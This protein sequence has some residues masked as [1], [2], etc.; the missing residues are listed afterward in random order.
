MI[1]N[2]LYLRDFGCYGE[3]SIDFTKHQVWLIKGK[4]RDRGG[5]S[6]GSGKSTIRD[7]ISWALWGV[8]RGL[9]KPGSDI[10]R[11]GKN[12]C[13]VYVEF[14]ANGKK[15][16]VLRSTGRSAILRFS[17]YQGQTVT[18]T[19]QEIIKFLGIDYDAFSKSACFEQGGSDAFS[20]LKPAEAKRYVINLL[21]LG[22]YSTLEQYCRRIYDQAQSQIQIY[23]RDVEMLSGKVED[24]KE[25][26]R[27][28]EVAQT[29]KARAEQNLSNASKAVETADSLLQDLQKKKSEEEKKFYALREELTA[30]VTQGRLQANRKVNFEALQGE[31]PTCVQEVPAQHKARISRTFDKTLN[32]LREKA[33]KIKAEVEAQESK[34]NSINIEEARRRVNTCRS[35]EQACQTELRNA[36]SALKEV[37]VRLES[38]SDYS[39][40]LYEKAKLLKEANDKA[41]VYRDLLSAFGKNGI[42]SH[43][44]EGVIPEIKSIT[45]QL[46]QTLTEGR[47]RVNLQVQKVL[48]SGDTGDTLE[49]VVTD[50]VGERPYA[51]YSG[52]ER[53]IIDFSLRIALSVLLSRRCGS[54]IQTLI[55]DEGLGALDED[56]RIKFVEALNLAASRFGFKRILLI[57]HATDVHDFFE[58]VIDIV[59]DRNGSRVVS[60]ELERPSVVAEPKAPKERTGEKGGIREAAVPMAAPTDDLW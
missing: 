7:A 49:I 57:T 29:S 20:R 32:E 39:A 43:I 14:E 36:S 52:G 21:N 3:T 47:M 44:I 5:S 17:E 50:E 24:S 25:L 22:V 38:S 28:Y 55:I 31:C 1:V 13:I 41:T 58:N 51:L 40:E 59:K 4:N 2:R 60:Q 33:S 46:V 16:W 48:K 12:E 37:Q 54:P 10:I 18:D 45:N 35:A 53:F 15:C 27:S 6:N 26:K 23:T 9:T 56:N 11:Q 30:L 42:P 8:A 19:Q 34:V